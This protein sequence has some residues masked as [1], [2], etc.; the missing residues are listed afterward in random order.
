MLAL[1]LGGAV[2][3]S[4]DLFDSVDPPARPVTRNSFGLHIVGVTGWDQADKKPTPVHTFGCKSVRIWDTGATWR[5]I[6]RNIASTDWSVLDSEISIWEKYFDDI[7]F[8]FG[9]APD[10]ASGIVQGRG[11]YNSVPPQDDGAIRNFLRA[12]LTRYPV[13]S[14]VQIWNEPN[15]PKYFSGTVDQ[16]AHI[17]GV[18]ANT[19]REFHPKV[20][21]IAASPQPYADHG[22]YFGR[23]LDAMMK[24]RVGDMMDVLS[25]HTYVQPGEPELMGPMIDALNAM[26][27]CRGF[28]QPIWST[29][30]G[31]GTFRDLE[32]GDVSKNTMMNPVQAAAYILRGF[33]MSLGHGI[34]RQYFY[35]VDKSFSALRLISFNKNSVTMAGVALNNL[36]DLLS[37]GQIGR[38]VQYPDYYEQIFI[39][40]EGRSGRIV[41]TRDGG[42]TRLALPAGAL[43]R[44]FWGRTL[45]VG[46]DAKVGIG[47]VPIYLT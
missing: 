39:D 21:V 45:E 24:L 8:C 6:Q 46:P 9:Q 26:A 4:V 43:A 15:F 41:W 38:P 33:L 23:Y 7:L 18:V 12:L 14:A 34:E 20:K 35:A 44:N 17:S 37:G 42:G 27:Q 5:L 13:I 16:L 28:H 36:V 31:W 25:Y 1:P 32:T 22:D 40:A 10:W 3:P 47:P 11:S 29:E 19:V 2:G 30:F